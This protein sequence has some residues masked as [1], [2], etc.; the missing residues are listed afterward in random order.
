MMNIKKSTWDWI[1]LWY[2][3][4]MCRCLKEQ[5][6]YGDWGWFLISINYLISFLFNRWL[7]TDEGWDNP[8]MGWRSSSDPYSVSSPWYYFM[9]K[10]YM[11]MYEVFYDGR[12]RFLFSTQKRKLWDIAM[13]MV[14]DSISS[15]LI[16]SI[17]YHI[18]Y[19][20]GQF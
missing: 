15:H 16:Y 3:V 18:I 1:W 6:I 17:L 5:L 9:I 11:Y 19:I 20:Y 2:W 4:C 12:A 7:S 8:L 13:R 14:R 10:W